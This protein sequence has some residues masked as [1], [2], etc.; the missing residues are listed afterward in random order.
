MT[1]QLQDLAEELGAQLFE[2]GAR[3]ATLTKAVRLACRIARH[4]IQDTERALARARLSN[5]GLV[6]ECVYSCGPFVLRNGFVGRLTKR[7]RTKYPGISLRIMELEGRPMWEIVVNGQADIAL[8]IQAPTSYPALISERQQLDKVE[9]VLVDSG[10]PLAH[11]KSVSV[12]DLREVPELLS[13]DNVRGTYLET[14]LLQY[15]RAADKE[16]ESPPNVEYLPSF[17]SMLAHARA[18]QGWTFIPSTVAHGY[19]P[20]VPVK[21]TDFPHAIPDGANVASHR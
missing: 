13:L 16:G 5:A 19:P 12:V 7:I 21:V 18:K 17:H 1:R 10:H 14:I 3:K 9:E 6:G 15:L 2:K 11:R 4:V 8:G 20:L